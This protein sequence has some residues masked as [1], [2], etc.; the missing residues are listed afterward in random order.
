MSGVH[1]VQAGCAEAG[2]LEAMLALHEAAFESMAHGVCVID[3]RERIGLINRRFLEMY[4]LSPAVVRV[5]ITFAD[6]LRHA[7]ERGNSLPGQADEHNNRRR[8][9]MAR[10]EPFRLVRQLPDGRVFNTSYRPL[11]AG[12]WMMM[13]EDVT[14]RQRREYDLRIQFERFDQATNHMSHGL[15]ATDGDS[16][17]VLF[18]QLFLEMYGL[19]S[20][21]IQVG[22][23][24]R[25]VIDHVAARGYF[26]N[27]SP[28]RIW[29]RRMEKM[30]ARKPFQ[31]YQNLR[32]GRE[33]ILHYH[34]MQDGGWVTLCEDVTE[35]YRMERELR[36]QFERFDQ[37]L[38]HMSHGLCMY[39]PDERLIVC[40]PRYLDIYGL[41]PKVVKPGIAH[42]DL[43]AHWIAQGNEPGM[44]AEAF[45]AKRK[46]AVAGKTLSTMLLH[47]KDGRVIEASTRQTPDGG[48]VSAH[49]DVTERLQYEERLKE[50]NLLFDAAIGNMAQALG[51]YDADNRLIVCND[52][53]ASFFNADPAVIKPGITLRQVF[54]HGVARGTYPGQTAD[55]L[56]E[57]RLASAGEG[58]SRSYDQRMADGRTLAVSISSM[59]KGGWVGTFS[60]VTDQ[61]KLEAENAAALIEQQQ[62]NL[63][64]DVALENMAHGLCVFDKDWR[65]IVRN[66]RY[67]EIYGLTSEEAQ[68][69]TPLV[70][71]IRLSLSRGVHESFRSAEE[72]FGDF[73]QRV[74]D[75][76]EPV[77]YRRLGSGRI[78]AVR[79]EPLANGGWVGTFEDITDR[80]RAAEELMEQH[81]LFN[82][83]LNN[84]AHGLAMMDVEM[85]L[86]VCNKRYVDMFGMSH[87]I[88]RPGATMRD[89]M[90]H[91]VAI[92]N[93]RHTGMTGDELYN[94]YVAALRAGNLVAHRHLADGRIIKLTHEVMPQG[95]WV[96]IYEDVTERHRAE[97][98]IAHMARHD[99]L[100]QLPNRV[101]LREK[102]AEGLARV[103][104]MDE[105]MAV[106]YLDLDNFKGINDTL[107]HPIGDKL[108]GTVAD[109]IRAVVG[110]HD[111]VAR[112]GGDEFAI[113]QRNS[114]PHAAGQ[115]ARRLVEIISEPM[116]IDGQE[117]NTGVSVGIAIAPSDGNAA[118]HLMKC[119]DLAL[120]RAKAEGRGTFR[121]FE[122]DMDARIQQRRALEVDLR[123]ALQAG[124][125]SLAYQPQINLASN[126]LV[127]MEALLRWNHAERGP[128]P[129]S[130]FIPLAEEMGLII[131]LGE[132][133]LRQACNEA[134]RWPDPVKVAVN[135]S[136]VQFRN[137]GLVTTVTQALASARLAPHRLE[138]EI[139]EAV[140]LQDN[141][142]T[143]GML[144]Q[145]RALGVRVAMD[146][147]GTGYSSLS[148]LRSFP[149]D[150]IKI[151]RS[152]I[153]DIERNSDSAVIIKA[154]AGL[155]ASLGIE[156]TA[157]GI[158]T[159]EQLEIVRR[160]GCTE[161]QGYLV[162]PPRPA[163]DVLGLIARFRRE[164]VAA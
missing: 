9:L 67:L 111:T 80:E 66:R 122:Q 91:S 98:S 138:L 104:E 108:L 36:L 41:D 40:N 1:S 59:P 12:G 69:G 82:V 51:M 29:A 74:V 37:A 87:E 19:S 26:P 4:N 46:Q 153:K 95:G 146:D 106:F 112:L 130:E 86:I 142:S 141:E 154:I 33:Y 144:H 50:Q 121:F 75:A 54:E 7:R 116:E 14:E 8:E 56:L 25:D 132:W 65:V 58:G 161:M 162:S 92:G 6:A 96:A 99:A 23:H 136:P 145:L 137:R 118:D 39:G 97:E 27:A 3:A 163:A 70:E 133:V 157:E 124:E 148:Y 21:V 107:G 34:P 30:A 125:F 143:V 114:N 110:E 93:Y 35:R 119:A 156:T 150:K 5:G 76:K 126:E 101:L 63:L 52:K 64:F 123:R 32:N 2:Q 149:F 73:V 53:Y 134:A 120:Y 17:I 78:I 61:R 24:M 79:H 135:L 155:G 105:A 81:R 22:V 16:R 128:V 84:M 129:P 45:Y 49:E 11:A 42:R 160:A 55:E 103:D 43:L 48:W 10:G 127:A 158:E 31:Q 72:F 90:A 94:G 18:N 164:V 60:D 62:Q 147:F 38:A 131:Q 89:V 83:A 47:L 77:L 113:L 20:D 71:L 68:P 159:P 151:D 13:V 109:R 152:F 88:A 140:L 115:L 15:C 44:S 57:R 139:T 28:D 117:I 102:M 85:R 100:T